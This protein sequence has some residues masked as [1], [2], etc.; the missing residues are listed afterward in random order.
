MTTTESQ[1]LPACP[2]CGAAMGELTEMHG[3]MVHGCYECVACA[4][5]AWPPELAWMSPDNN[6]FRGDAEESDDVTRYLEVGK[7]LVVSVL[8]ADR[9]RLV[10]GEAALVQLKQTFAPCDLDR[11]LFYLVQ[12]GIMERENMLVPVPPN[13]A[14][15][16]AGVAAHKAPAVVLA[17]V[18]TPGQLMRE[19]FPALPVFAARPL[20]EA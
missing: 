13:R 9:A 2:N 5:V 1:S 15:R 17:I 16:R 19:E 4:I 7:A 14:Q 10:L 6:P 20:G 3:V 12:A 18:L 8:H 11:L